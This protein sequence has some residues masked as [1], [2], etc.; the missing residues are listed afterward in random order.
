MKTYK[1]T[2]TF[3]N[4][5]GHIYTLTVEC[6]GFIQAFFLLTA[7]AIRTGK[8]YQLNTIQ[9]DERGGSVVKVDNINKVSSLLM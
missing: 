9:D 1:Y 6:N 2:G 5:D 8:H 4:S 3:K 7:D